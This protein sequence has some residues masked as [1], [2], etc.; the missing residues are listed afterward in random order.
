MI[1]TAAIALFT[2]ACFAGCDSN[3]NRVEGVC[4]CTFVRGEPQEYD[5]RELNRADQVTECQ[6]NNS[7]AANFGGTCK[8]E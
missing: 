1:R 4:Y 7:N 3:D 2:M 8:L 6:R 5:L